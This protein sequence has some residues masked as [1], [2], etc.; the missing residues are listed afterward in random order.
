MSV[1]IEVV[2]SDGHRLG[3]CRVDPAGKPR[4]AVV[5]IQEVFGVNDYVHSV[6]Q[7]YANE[8]YV[9]IAPAL[10]DRQSKGAAFGYDD[11][12]SARKLRAGLVWSDVVKDI[13]AAVKAVSAAGK[14]GIVGYC[15]GG[16]AAWMA[17]QHLDLACAVA[18]YG[19]DIVS[20]LDKPPRCPI[21]INYAESD[22]SISAEDVETVRAA[23][24]ELPIYV[25]PAAHGFDC[26]GRPYFEPKSA[27]TARVRTLQLF[28][29]FIG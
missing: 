4:G 10:Y 23:Y 22:H 28:R 21:I 5:V 8:G 11:I 2:A 17:A 7:R 14:V 24:P 25:W 18:Y 12:L 6:C 20:T 9:S 19:R 29:K 1:N 3:A 16:S 27:Q 13:E 15:V 26:D